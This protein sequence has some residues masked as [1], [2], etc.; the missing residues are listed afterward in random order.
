[1][2]IVYCIERITGTGGLQHILIDKMNYLADH[3][4]HEIILMTVWHNEKPLA[5][6]LSNNVRRV[7]LNVPKHLYPMAMHRFN[8]MMKKLNP[9]VCIV[10]R[11]VGAFLASF[12]SWKGR[13]IYES[14]Q[15]LETMNH[16]WVY[17]LMMNKIDTAVCLTHGDAR[18]FPKVKHVEVIPNFTE[19]KA[20]RLPDYSAKNVV[21]VGRDCPEKDIPRLHRIWDEIQETH[22]DWKLSIHHNTKDIVKAYLEGSILVMTSKAEGFPLVLI[23]AMSCG[24]PCIAF[25]CP[26]GPSEIIEDGKTGY[27][28]PYDNDKA[29]I[30]KLDY[31]MNNPEERER[32]GKEGQKCAKRFNKSEIMNKFL[33]VFGGQRV[34]VKG[35]RSEVR[36]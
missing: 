13:I 17:P 3:T 24:L 34:K 19:I 2:R 20:D 11:A 6:P 10:F 29:F 1:M 23:E 21:F 30:E 5:Y 15:P 9:E 27:L 33:K 35:Q 18:N 28:I 14:H 32:M 7:E 4:C 22:P 8:S 26:Y 36:G 25:N 16:R 31:L 12:T